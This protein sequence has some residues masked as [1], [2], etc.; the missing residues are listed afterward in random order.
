MLVALLVSILVLLAWSSLNIHFRELGILLQRSAYLEDGLGQTHLA[1]KF[2]N[3]MKIYQKQ[4]S[5]EQADEQEFALNQ[6]LSSRSRSV[7]SYVVAINGLDKF[8]V[9]LINGM[10]K[11]MG[12]PAL[13]QGD[14]ATLI[15]DLEFA[16]HLERIKEYG[17]AI[18]LYENT[19]SQHAF[20]EPRIRSIINLHEGF[21]LANL[22]NMERAVP[23][24]RKV[25][26]TES[27]NDLG[28]TAA[29]L[30]DYLEAIQREGQ[31]IQEN[32]LASAKKF[33]ELLQC[34]Q[35]KSILDT[36]TLKNAEE[37]AEVA[38]IR[39]RCLEE[40]GK[41]G[42]AAQ[43]YL[44]ALKSKTNHK[45]VADANRRI[46]MVGTQSAHSGSLLKE[47]A[48]KVNTVVKDSSLMRME[49]RLAG[50]EGD[51]LG[52]RSG[53]PS[54]NP[55]A[56]NQIESLA[57]DLYETTFK[58]QLA[59]QG[60]NL[61]PQAGTRVR[62]NIAGGKSISGKILSQPGEKIVRIQTMIGVIGITR[63]DIRSVEIQ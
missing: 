16:F 40:R 28:I 21:C 41:K 36:L 57:K 9:L 31:N 15:S 45:V 17:M 8:N 32:G 62:L 24:F 51:S 30:L 22:G 54:L 34:T 46:F 11:L 33:S 38:L 48:S 49:T 6:I 4:I 27:S 20:L 39:G 7:Q 59:M 60:E 3:Q 37:K 44:Q 35:A 23:L 63:Q 13:P 10:R 43:Y 5:Q 2:I 26:A 19:V 50:E 18:A 61:L 12:Q 47:I 55:E 56:L 25:L 52:T 58:N 1:A 29:I 53:E 14:A 42:D